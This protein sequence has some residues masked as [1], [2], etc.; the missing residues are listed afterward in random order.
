MPQTSSTTA[1]IPTPF[2]YSP[3]PY[4][5]PFQSLAAVQND[6]SRTP[7]NAITCHSPNPENRPPPRASPQHRSHTSRIQ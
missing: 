6:P 1:A 4:S 2:P 3:I 5:L 7:F